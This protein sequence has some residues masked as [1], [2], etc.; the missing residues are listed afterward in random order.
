MNAGNPAVKVRPSRFLWNYRADGSP[1]ARLERVLA[2]GRAFL[3]VSG[4]IAIYIDPTEPARLAE[5]TYAVLFG[6]ALYSMIVLA[7]VHRATRLGSRDGQILH[8]IDILWTALLTFIS[9][10]PGSPFFLFF[11]FVQ[12]AAAYRWGFRETLL[13][14][15]MT[16]GIFLVETGIA[17]A[18]NPTL[19]PWQDLETNRTILRVVYFVL[20]GCLIGYLAEQE[21]DLRAEIAAVADAGRQPRVELG[22]GGSVTAVSLELLRIFDAAAVHVVIQDFETRRTMLWRVEGRGTSDEARRTLH[23]ELDPSQQAAWL[24]DD[25]GHAWH[26]RTAPDTSTLLARVVEPGVWPL[27]RTTVTLPRALSETREFTTVTAGNMGLCEEWRGRV[28]LFDA[29]NTENL[30]RSLHFLEAVTEHITPALTNVF[31]L[32]RLRSRA[33]AVERARVARELHDGAIQALF[34]IEMRIDALRRRAKFRPDDVATELAEVQ[35]LLRS[36]VLEL[37]ELMQ[38]LRPID[39]ET[40]DQLPDVLASLVERFR[41]DTGVSA[42]FVFDGGPVSLPAPTALELARIVQEALVNVRKHSRA[43]NVL[44]RLTNTDQACTLVVEDD[45]QGFDFEGRLSDRELEERR[46]GPAIIKERARIAG[47]QLAVDSAP[48]IGA[49]LE[50]TLEAGVHA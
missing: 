29:A 47:A 9:S 48:G 33:G 17:G 35:E 39:L 25:P 34:G 20:T 23:V 1:A 8:G 43:R 11:L 50:L 14:T 45:G 3:T 2:I 28:Y 7:F 12:L 18:W 15:T 40:S 24:F 19:F 6:Y 42:R 21:K 30:E 32:R 10:G 31:L 41:R 4:L 27:Q 44:V 13:T 5:L 46:V 37:R 22:L 36:E 38:A 26:A 49:R 16:V